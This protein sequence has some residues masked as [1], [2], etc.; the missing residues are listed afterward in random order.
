MVLEDKYESVLD[1]WKKLRIFWYLA[2]F[3]SSLQQL[4]HFVNLSLGQVSRKNTKILHFETLELTVW[5]DQ[6]G[7]REDWVQCWG[8]WADPDTAQPPSPDHTPHTSTHHQ[9][10]W[11]G[12]HHNHCTALLQIL[13][14]TLI[15]HCILNKQTS[16]RGVFVQV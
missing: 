8:W 7:E 5:T 13:F 11:S 16:F 14:Q 2:P 6:L 12:Y 4:K 10:S 15:H 1:I 9:W 3:A